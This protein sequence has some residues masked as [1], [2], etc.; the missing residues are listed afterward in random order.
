[1]A[2]ERFCVESACW[3]IDRR[4]I[5]L[6]YFREMLQGNIIPETVAGGARSLER[7][8]ELTPSRNTEA[9]DGA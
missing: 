9:Q 6:K 3:A 4:I 8:P 2:S 5:D 1:M 7:Y